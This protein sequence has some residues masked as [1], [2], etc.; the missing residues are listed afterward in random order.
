MRDRRLPNLI[1]SY[2]QTLFG[3]Q[4]RMPKSERPTVW[5]VNG[6]IL[7]GNSLKYGSSDGSRN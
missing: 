4:L 1:N 6:D 2:Q 7:K 3:L 5:R